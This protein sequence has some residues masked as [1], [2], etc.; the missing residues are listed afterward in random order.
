MEEGRG[1]VVPHHMR[2]IGTARG[3]RC[4]CC[5]CSIEQQAGRIDTRIPQGQVHVIPLLVDVLLVAGHRCRSY[6][7]GQIGRYQH[8]PD[9]PLV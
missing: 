9:V 7:P 1:D 6:W 8:D 3:S 2:G 5:G 4:R